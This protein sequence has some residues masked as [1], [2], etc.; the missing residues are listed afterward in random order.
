M[1]HLKNY[2]ILLCVLLLIT[3]PFALATYENVTIYYNNEPL[4]FPT[5]GPYYDAQE[6]C[7]MVPVRTFA[8]E[9]GAQ[10]DFDADS[11]DISIS[12]LDTQ[13][14]LNA[15]RQEAIVNDTRR[16]TLAAALSIQDGISF[17]PL[18]AF[19]DALNINYRWDIDTLTAHLSLAK[20]YA[21][22]MDANQIPYNYGTPKRS[23]RSEQGFDWQVYQDVPSSFSMVG[24]DNEKVVAY[25]LYQ[26]SWELPC[27]LYCGMPVDNANSL[28]QIQKYSIGIGNYSIVYTSETEYIVAYLDPEGESV[29]AVLYEDIAYKDQYEI[30]A[31]V[32]ESFSLQLQ[33]LFNAY[34]SGLGYEAISE[35]S[36]LTALAKKHADDMAQHNYFG[37]LDT[38]G[39]SNEDRFAQAGYGDCYCA[40]ATAQA[41]RNSFDAFAGLVAN[42]DYQALAAANF[43]SS[44]CGT[45]YHSDSDGLLY[46]VQIFYAPKE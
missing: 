5:A 42:T 38:Q 28:M 13:I 24:I 25:Y 34:R 21:L 31:S 43:Q 1:Q 19:T 18:N 29:C 36:G 22:G 39:L 45:A 3:S 32:T 17:V 15:N 16:I 6:N 44:G 2:F 27:G 8:E 14:S 26:G 23:D 35:D 9:I 7:I 33:D 12:I 46:F 20:T 40:E 10:V 37:H 4:A 41:Y 11:G 30:D